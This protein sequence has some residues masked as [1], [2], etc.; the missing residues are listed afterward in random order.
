MMSLC[1]SLPMPKCQCH[2]VEQELAKN[3]HYPGRTYWRCKVKRL[4]SRRKY[5]AKPSTYVLKRKWTLNQIMEEL[6]V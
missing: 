4:A 2:G 1:Y 3:Y 6:S 5:N